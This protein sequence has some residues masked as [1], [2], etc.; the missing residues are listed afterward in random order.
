[1]GTRQRCDTMPYEQFKR[2]PRQVLAYGI[3]LT[4]LLW[5][6]VLAATGCSWLGFIAQGVAGGEQTVIVPA[7]YKGLNGQTVAVAVVADE[8][9]LYEH[10]QAPLAIGQELAR[11]LAIQL[12][13]A[14]VIDA[15]QVHQYQTQ[16]PYWHTTPLAQLLSQI[17]VTRLV[18]IDVIRYS[19]HEPG[20][21]YQ[22]R[23]A[24]TAR[25]SVAEAHAADPDDFVFAKTLAAYFPPD[26]P[27]GRVDPDDSIVKLGLHRHFAQEV[28]KLFHDHE[29]TV[30]DP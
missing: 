17:G 23:G 5:I 29:V 1:M 18:L 20:N 13:E 12:P 26:N 2:S 30:S 25:V 15:Q 27:V 28:T 9:T 11:Q 8:Y 24:M 3:P 10:P 4:R 16:H 14:Q 22:Q 21:A 6:C 7:A 19:T